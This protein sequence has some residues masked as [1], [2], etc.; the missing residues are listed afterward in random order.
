MKKI[1]F[2]GLGIM[3]NPMAGNLLKK[4]YSLTVY[5]IVPGK[6]DEAVA[7]GAKAG[8]SSKDVAEKSE[9]VITMLPN[10]PDVKDAVLGENGV[11]DGAKPGTIQRSGY[12]RCPGERR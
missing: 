6:T 9:I 8:S 2:I 11:L 5:D 1:G 12:A 7:A 3:G 4:G 10:S